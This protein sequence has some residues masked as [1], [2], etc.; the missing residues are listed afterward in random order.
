[1]SKQCCMPSV[2][3]IGEGEGLA[4]WVEGVCGGEGY[5]PCILESL[6]GG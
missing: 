3:E 1:M 2:G 4:W 5:C 6:C